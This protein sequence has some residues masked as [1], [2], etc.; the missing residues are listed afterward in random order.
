LRRGI[1]D[2]KWFKLKNIM[3]NLYYTYWVDAIVSINTKNPNRKD[4]KYTLF[5]YTT[6]CNA[7]NVW[8]VMLW[9]KFFN[10][11]FFRVEI[12]ILS[13]SILGNAIGFIIYFASPFIILNY[14]L[15]FY[16]DRYKKLLDKYTHRNGKFAM[17]YIFYSILLGSIS[18]V[19]YGFIK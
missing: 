9:L 19:I 18:A 4:W 14:L 5:I 6:L 15:I 12:D 11:F 13:G 2:A 8:V 3:I 7:L 16:K 1:D 17:G 10:I